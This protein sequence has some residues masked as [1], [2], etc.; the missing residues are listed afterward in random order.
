[1]K[2]ATQTPNL[3]SFLLQVLLDG[4]LLVIPFVSIL[5]LLGAGH[6]YRAPNWWL[7]GLCGAALLTSIVRALVVLSKLLRALRDQ[8]WGPSL[9]TVLRIAL[10]ALAIYTNGFALMILLGAGVSVGE[11]VG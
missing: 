11:P 4:L 7:I 8:K 3:L 6:A 9:G 5:Y 2:P 1:M 10:L